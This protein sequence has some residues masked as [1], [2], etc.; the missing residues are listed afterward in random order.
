M[1]VVTEYIVCMYVR[2]YVLTC[3]GGIPSATNRGFDLPGEG[4]VQFQF[5]ESAEA[6]NAG[7][8]ANTYTIYLPLLLDHSDASKLLSC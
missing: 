4:E 2:T 5:H 1:P 7:A 3:V 8:Y 6:S